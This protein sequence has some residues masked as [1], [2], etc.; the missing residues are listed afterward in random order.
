MFACRKRWG[1]TSIYNK[2]WNIDVYSIF[3]VGYM[4]VSLL[5][6]HEVNKGFLF[7]SLFLYA[8]IF[9]AV[10]KDIRKVWR[11]ANILLRILILT[12][13]SLVL[14]SNVQLFGSYQ[15]QNIPRHIGGGKAE[16]AFVMISKQHQE[17]AHFLDI[18]DSKNEYTDGGVMGPIKIIIRSDKEVVFINDTELA[19]AEYQTNKTTSITTNWYSADK[20]KKVTEALKTNTVITITTNMPQ[21]GTHVVAKQIRADLVD[22]IIF[23]K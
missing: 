16:T 6:N 20:N 19:S 21:A 18:P 23:A 1:H 3:L 12:F 14:I 22:G 17:L 9:F 8:L 7:F 10:G 11:G 13:I 5:L 4:M 15:F 2:V